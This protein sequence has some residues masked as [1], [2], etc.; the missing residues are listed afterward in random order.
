[1]RAELPSRQVQDYAQ[2]AGWY[3]E[4]IFKNGQ[5]RPKNTNSGRVLGQ[6]PQSL[7]DTY[8]VGISYYPISPDDRRAH[9]FWDCMGETTFKP[10]HQL[11]LS[12]YCSRVGPLK[13]ED[14]F[15]IEIL[16]GIKQGN[17][18][19]SE[20]PHTLFDRW[21]ITV[22]EPETVDYEGDEEPAY[23]GRFLLRNER[24]QNAGFYSKEYSKWIQ[25]WGYPC[26]DTLLMSPDVDKDGSFFQRE[27]LA[28]RDM[29]NHSYEWQNK[30][31]MK[32]SVAKNVGHLLTA[33][34]EIT[35]QFHK[36]LYNNKHE[37]QYDFGEATDAAIAVGE[38]MT[39]KPSKLRSLQYF[40]RK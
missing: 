11:L 38:A 4:A 29:S 37:K 14:T 30:L 2:K 19:I 25:G 26:I 18:P 16:E 28:Y 32:K 39:N 20:F 10:S 1:M 21:D 40:S 22:H 27:V 33:F 3:A 23:A 36:G 12:T 15:L 35:L 34:S 24:L 31:K 13:D 6:L 7:G 9:A 5:L 17:V 8:F